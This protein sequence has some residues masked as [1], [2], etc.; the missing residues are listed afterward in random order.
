MQKLFKDLS[1]SQEQLNVVVIDIK[2]TVAVEEFD[3]VLLNTQEAVMSHD[4]NTLIVISG[5]EGK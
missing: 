5:R 4:S 3:Q 1:D 2:E